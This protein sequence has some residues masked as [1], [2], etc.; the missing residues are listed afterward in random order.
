M[1]NN[2]NKKQAKEWKIS[3][4]FGTRD[5]IRVLM[6]LKGEKELPEE[7]IKKFALNQNILLKKEHAGKKGAEAKATEDEQFSAFRESL[8]FYKAAIEDLERYKNDFANKRYGEIFAKENKDLQLLQTIAG[9]AQAIGYFANNVLSNNV[10]VNGISDN[11]SE[12]LISIWNKAGAM[13][14]LFGAIKTEYGNLCRMTPNQLCS[15]GYKGSEKFGNYDQDLKELEESHKKR[16]NNAKNKVKR[17][18][19][20][21]KK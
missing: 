15:E 16:W 13:E 6:P 12:E 14:R 17:E 21:K 11:E 10:L 4:G 9:K 3:M 8:P 20:N 2:Y 1:T 18:A 5:V 7:D 19:R